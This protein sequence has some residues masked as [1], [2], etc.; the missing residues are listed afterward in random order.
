MRETEGL[1]YDAGT[2]FDRG[3]GTVTAHVGFDPANAARVEE[4]V[5]AEVAD[6]QAEPVDDD[7]LDDARKFAVQRASEIEDDPGLRIAFSYARALGGRPDFTVEDL[8]AGFRGV[9]VADVQKVA[10]RLHLDS[11]YLLTS[12]T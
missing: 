2:I 8:I 12:T 10:Q 11:I 5:R 6:L 1:A 4:L 9:T 7:E 3:K